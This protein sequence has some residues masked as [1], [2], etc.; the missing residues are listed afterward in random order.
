MNIYEVKTPAELLSGN[1][2]PGRGIVLGRTPDGKKAVA[3]YFIMG[4]SENSRNRV[5]Q[6]RGGEVF[7]EPF[8]ASKVKDPSLIIYAAIRSYENNLI[9]TNG[10]QTDTVYDGLKA[11]KTFSEA[12]KSRCFEPDG[13]NFTPRISGMITFGDGDF[14]YQMSILKSADAQGSAC[15]RYTFD[16]A[17][18]AG[19][20]HFLH[21]YVTDG[22]PIPT[23]QGEPERMAVDNDIDVFTDALWNSLNADNRISLYVRYVDL[24]TGEAEN[25]LINQNK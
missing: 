12:L 22:N 8:D 19:V 9:V 7:T 23:F 14:C 5:F 3:A 21:T 13:P 25:R 6:E 18:I 1:P 10:D 11:G 16:Y 24:Q 17:P 15:H 20:G 2:Y 4:R